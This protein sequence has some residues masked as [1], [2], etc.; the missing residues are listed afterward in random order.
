MKIRNMQKNPVSEKSDAAERK[1]ER[2]MGAAKKQRMNGKKE[3][4]KKSRKGYK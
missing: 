2:K 3:I 4:K 1:K